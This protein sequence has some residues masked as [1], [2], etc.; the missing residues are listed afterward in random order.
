MSN[1]EVEVHGITMWG[2]KHVVLER[3]MMHWCSK[4]SPDHSRLTRMLLSSC[5][6]DP[7][8]HEISFH[9]PDF[10]ICSQINECVCLK[11]FQNDIIGLP[12]KAWEQFMDEDGSIFEHWFAAVCPKLAETDMSEPPEWAKWNRIYSWQGSCWLARRGSEPPSNC[13]LTA[14]CPASFLL[15]WWVRMIFTLPALTPVECHQGC[16]P[17]Q[18]A[19]GL[20]GKLWGLHTRSHWPT[21]CRHTR[22]QPKPRLFQG[23]CQ[24]VGSLAGKD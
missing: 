14:R 1:G 9:W 10:P 6:Y 17:S 20:S 19:S 24:R 2:G 12:K 7:G 8:G 22:K 13:A 15:S 21:G 5:S 3:S 18:A 11:A 4:M 23:T 16:P